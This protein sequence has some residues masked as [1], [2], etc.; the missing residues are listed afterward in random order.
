[1]NG[2]KKDIDIALNNSDSDLLVSSTYSRLIVDA[3]VKQGQKPLARDFLL[4]IV[5]LHS[6]AD[7]ARA[8]LATIYKDLGNI[9]R[10]REEAEYILHAGINPASRKAAQA[11]LDA[12]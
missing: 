12:L 9:K 8:Q 2:G 7:Y 10:A 11:F 5:D 6:T 4:K 3:Y 1:M